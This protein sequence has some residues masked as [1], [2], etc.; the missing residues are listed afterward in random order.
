[1]Q[2]DAPLVINVDNADI[3]ATLITLKSEVE[4]DL[5]L[6]APLRFTL[7]GAQEAHM[8]AKELGEAGVGV[9]LTQP[10]PFP[11]RWDAHRM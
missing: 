6:V 9:I 2:G 4:R 5:A 11:Q 7:V 8:L 1:M 10:R 3:I